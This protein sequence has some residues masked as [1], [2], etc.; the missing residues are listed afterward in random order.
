V[1]RASTFTWP[2]RRPGDFTHD[3]VLDFLAADIQVN[4]AAA[5]A[6]VAHVE[7]VESGAEPGCR[8]IGNLYD[9]RLSAEGALLENIYDEAYKG[10]ASLEDFATAARAWLRYV[11][12]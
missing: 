12:D 5:A 6:L 1:S 10:S 3:L 2:G 11:Q 9:L 7:A 8:R 4:P